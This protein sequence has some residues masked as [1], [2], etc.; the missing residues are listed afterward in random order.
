MFGAGLHLD[1]GAYTSY[2]L[3]PTPQSPVGSEC[4]D[5]KGEISRPTLNTLIKLGDSN[6]QKAEDRRRTGARQRTGKEQ[7]SQNKETIL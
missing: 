7:T 5:V 3:N 1:A 2:G 6:E 4:V